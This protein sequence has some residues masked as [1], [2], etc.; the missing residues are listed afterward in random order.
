MSSLAGIN[1]HLNVFVYTFLWEGEREGAFILFQ[2]NRKECFSHF[3]SVYTHT[4]SQS[5]A[6]NAFPLPCKIY[7]DSEIMLELL[8]K[9]GGSMSHLEIPP[10][11]PF[12]LCF[13][14]HFCSV[15]TLTGVIFRDDA[16]LSSRQFSKLNSTSEWGNVFCYYCVFEE[17]WRYLVNEVLNIYCWVRGFST[18]K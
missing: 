11:I 6:S 17:G 9:M 18:W 15:F 1:G 12:S 7:S 14:H 13:P 16:L 3:L 4:H 10:N 2:I 5:G 8:L